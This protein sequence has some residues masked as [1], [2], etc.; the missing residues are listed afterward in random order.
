MARFGRA[1][2]A[3]MVWA[4]AAVCRQA[5]WAWCWSTHS[6]AR[7]CDASWAAPYVNSL[8]ARRTDMAY[9]TVWLRTRRA[10]SRPAAS[11]G[12]RSVLTR[13]PPIGRAHR[14]QTLSP[15][16]RFCPWQTSSAAPALRRPSSR[17]PAGLPCQATTASGGRRIGPASLHDCA[18]PAP[19][20]LPQAL[21]I[22]I[23]L[24]AGLRTGYPGQPGWGI[25]GTPAIV[26][27]PG[28]GGAARIFSACHLRTCSAQLAS[29]SLVQNAFRAAASG[30][31]AASTPSTL[32]KYK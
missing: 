6:R 16:T 22:A 10:A 30:F 8:G 5:I 2:L 11:L 19:P 24:P 15:I 9:G 27:G 3:P 32:L 17:T 20:A 12:N 23:A 28:T 25:H 7:L 26:P 21:K 4:W 18:E 29:R 31:I 13:S 1:R 14:L